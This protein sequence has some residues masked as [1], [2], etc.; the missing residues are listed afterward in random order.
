VLLGTSIWFAQIATHVREGTDYDLHAVAVGSIVVFVISF[1]A[2]AAC[3]VVG[4]LSESG[5]T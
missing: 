2:G 1:L 4:E 5:T 3:I